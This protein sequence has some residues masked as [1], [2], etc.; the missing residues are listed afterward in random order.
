MSERQTILIQPLGFDS[1]TSIAATELASYLPRLADVDTLVLPAL[2]TIPSKSQPQIV[3]GTSEA[4]A[5]MG[6]GTIPKVN[7]LDDEIALISK[8]GILYLVG[9]NPRSVLFAAYRL[10]EELGVVFLRPGPA[11]E[12]IPHT[13]KLKLPTKA[14]REK[15]S[16][17]HRGICIEGAPRLEHAL[18]ILDWMVKKKMNTF[19]LQFRHSGVFW[20]RGYSSPEMDERSKEYRLSEEECYALDD[21]V[22]AKLQDLGLILHR[23][24]HGWTGYV[25]DVPSLDWER[26]DIQPPTEKMGWL[27]EVKGK[28]KVLYDIAA[29]TELCYSQPKVRDA[30]VADVVHYAWQH[31][32][33]D[34]LHVWMS[35]SFNN[36]CECAKCRK[37]PPTDWYVMIID[38]IGKQ[39]E[40]EGLQTRVVFLA[41]Q[42]L[43]WPPQEIRLTTDNV[44]FMYAPITRC[45][46][47]TLVD[48]KC[49]EGRKW[50]LP[51]LNETKLFESNRPF[52][53]IARQWQALEM[54]DSFVFDYYL[55]WEVFQDGFGQDMGTV[56]AKDMASLSDLGL[57]GLVSCQ[58]LRAFYPLPY[59]PSAMAD[60]L[61]NKKQ[62]VK[63][64]RSRIMT[65]AFDKHTPEVEE[66][67][68][69]MV[70]DFQI[71]NEYEHR[72]IGSYDRSEE[73]KK[74]QQ[75]ASRAH[76]AR[77]RLLS[78]AKREKNDVVSLSLRLLAIHAEHAEL[79]ARIHQAGSAKEVKKIE[80]IREAYQARLPEILSEFTPWIDPMIGG[81][82]RGA[83]RSAEQA[84]RESSVD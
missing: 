81:I 80:T 82:I 35:D 15:A 13:K 43:L 44:V 63:A 17:R 10:L 7:E 22:V 46:R 16:Y 66:Y 76:A 45:F 27:A 56:M 73:R 30:F 18:D 1:P 62:S 77:K 60:F 72:S 9:A 79:L 55:W 8:K 42:D 58:C 23:V 4:C 57:N 26:T 51:P 75:I 11:G 33:V 32:E 47:H 34:V 68:M 53:E 6:L 14:I 65:A 39:L 12:V 49:D 38:A 54:P 24:G 31:P 2:S 3:L 59:L 74:L 71:G 48:K 84:A 20:R 67:F 29:A 52:A 40:V 19:Q 69:H 21:R 5:D 37:R 64:H 28:R 61:W 36:K 25:V 83:L 70:R 50:D 41:Y 78:L